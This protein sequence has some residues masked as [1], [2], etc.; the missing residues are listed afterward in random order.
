MNSEIMARARGGAWGGLGTRSNARSSR[1]MCGVASKFSSR[2]NQANAMP[3][4]PCALRIRNCLRVRSSEGIMRLFPW[5]GEGRLFHVQKLVG[6]E[7]DLAQI[8]QG[9]DAR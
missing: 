6:A 8:D 5:L 3:P 4:M 9:V 7:Q 1:G 2:N